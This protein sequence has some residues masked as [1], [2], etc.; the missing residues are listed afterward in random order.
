MPAGYE[1]FNPV[2]FVTKWKTPMLVIHGDAGL[3]HSR[4]PGPV[5]VHGAATPGHRE[6]VAV[7]PGENHWV[8]K[9]ANSVLWYHTVLAWLDRWIH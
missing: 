3:P 5:G 6:Q 7:F 4:H 2:D 8:L 9:P 1:K